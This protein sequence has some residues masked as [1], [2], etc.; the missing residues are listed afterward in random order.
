VLLWESLA[1]NALVANAKTSV[2]N[3][4]RKNNVDFIT[5]PLIL[6]PQFRG[7]QFG[8]AFFEPAINFS[9]HCLMTCNSSAWF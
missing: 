5:A 3:M 9:I 7:N 8:A 4:I 1:A 6:S 2:E